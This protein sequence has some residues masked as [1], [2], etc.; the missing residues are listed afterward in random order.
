MSVWDLSSYRWNIYALP[1]FVTAVILL[2]FGAFI[3]TRKIK[4][5]TSW[6]YFFECVVLSIWLGGFGIG[7]LSQT[8]ETADF[9]FRWA[10]IGA[11]NICFGNYLFT[12][13]FLKIA[14]GRKVLLA[15]AGIFSTSMV[16]ASFWPRLY[17]YVI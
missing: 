5:L 2:S 15:M 8:A 12:T 10:W 14:K 9:W 4:A 17:S 3:L 1:N 11:W 7:Y 13:S 16:L 6:A